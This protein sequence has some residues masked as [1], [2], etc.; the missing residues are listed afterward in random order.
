MKGTIRVMPNYR[1]RRI[2]GEFGV[3]VFVSDD[4]ASSEV[5][6]TPR[7]ARAVA[8]RLLASAQRAE[9]D[10][11]RAAKMES[12]MRTATSMA[13]SLLEPKP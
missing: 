6:L 9:R 1:R 4:G 5:E 8:I 12:R 3:S 7:E 10:A 11:T 13:Q 2:S